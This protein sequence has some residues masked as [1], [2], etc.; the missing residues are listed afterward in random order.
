MAETKE[1][2]KCEYVALI[3]I[4]GECKVRGDVQDTLRMLGVEN[5]NNMA[6]HKKT[7]SIMGMIQKVQGYIAFGEVDKK[8]ADSYGLKTTVKMHPPRGG[9]ER[10]GIKV[11]FA[12]GGVLGDRGE[13][14]NDLISR[15]I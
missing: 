9:F 1:T 15:M 3:R 11:P 5:K 6:I 4:R 7:P 2:S 12:A 13:K 8:L 14:I 10:K